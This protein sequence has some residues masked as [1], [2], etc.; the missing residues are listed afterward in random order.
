MIIGGVG[1]AARLER[2]EVARP[3]T[4]TDAETLRVDLYL[5]AQKE[6]RRVLK[7]PG[8]ARFPRAVWDAGEIKVSQMPDGTYRVFAWVDSENSFGAL[9]RDQWMVEFDAQKQP[10]RV[11]LG[12]REWRFSPPAQGT[13]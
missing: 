2:A 13:P 12:E 3:D 1:Q 9:L 8:T 5:R 6:V 7:S 4:E 11:L 10:L